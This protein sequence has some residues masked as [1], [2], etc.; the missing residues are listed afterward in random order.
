M[1]LEIV[2]IPMA[3]ALVTKAKS[4]A[5]EKVPNASAHQVSVETRMK[6]QDLLVSIF[7]YLF[8]RQSVCQPK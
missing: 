6:N 5:D 4:K 2:L 3:I 7:H 1:S 8:I